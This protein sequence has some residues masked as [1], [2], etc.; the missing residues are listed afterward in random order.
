MTMRVSMD[1][2]RGR[3]HVH[4]NCKDLEP[5]KETTAHRYEGHEAAAATRLASSERPKVCAAALT[6][7]RAKT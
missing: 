6:G 2:T 4:G 3:G 7:V 5:G 1:L